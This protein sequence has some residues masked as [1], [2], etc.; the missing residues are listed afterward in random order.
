MAVLLSLP[1]V[2]VNTCWSLSL[3]V[4]LHPWACSVSLTTLLSLWFSA[5]SVSTLPPSVWG[6][7]DEVGAAFCCPLFSVLPGQ[8][9]WA[10]CLQLSKQR[11]SCSLRH[12]LIHP[13]HLHWTCRCYHHKVPGS[14]QSC[15]HSWHPNIPLWLYSFTFS[16]GTEPL[17]SPGLTYPGSHVCWVQ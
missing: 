10:P 9:G 5:L 8:F 2:P 16:L 14:A 12:S 6:Q 4:C 15:A 1:A 11:P 13:E 17:P 7:L 3:S